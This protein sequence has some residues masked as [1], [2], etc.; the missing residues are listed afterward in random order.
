LKHIDKLGLNCRY[1]VE[2]PDGEFLV[3]TSEG[4]AV[5]NPGNWVFQRLKLSVNGELPG[6]VSRLVP[7]DK[8]S[9]LGISNTGLFVYNSERNSILY[10]LNKLLKNENQNYTT[11]FKDSRGIVWV[12][13]QDGLI[14]WQPSKTKLNSL[15]TDDG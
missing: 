3:A 10:P 5:F 11:I 2:K 14:V 6:S 1:I 8:H 4:L 7:F 9:F 12:G 15:F 13:T